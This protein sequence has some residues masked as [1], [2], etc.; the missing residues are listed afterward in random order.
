MGK[1]L[2]LLHYHSESLFYMRVHAW[3]CTFYGIYE[4]IMTGSHHFNIIQSIFTALK[5]LC[6]IPIY[7]SLVPNALDIFI[8]STV[9]HFSQNVI[10][11]HSYSMYGFSDWLLSLN[12][13]HL[14][15]LYILSWIDSSFP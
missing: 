9:L 2:Q 15:F 13:M 8:T 6:A 12:N 7:P 1:L 14:S 5:I 4:C 3:Y 10:L 11:L